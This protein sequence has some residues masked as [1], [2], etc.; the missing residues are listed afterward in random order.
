[1]AWVL[2][3][4]WGYRGHEIIGNGVDKYFD[5][6]MSQFH[7]WTPFLASHSSDAD[8]RK[9]S[10]KSEGS[11]HYLDID[12][13]PEFIETG[14]I[15]RNLDTLLALYGRSFVESQGY[16]PWATITSYD[17]L[18][19]CFKRL[20]FDKAQFFAADLSHYVA[21]GYMPL[22]LTRNYDG[23]YSNNKGIHG[24]YESDMIGMFG[25][26]VNLEGGKVEKV[27]SVSDYIFTYMFENYIY[28]DS[29]LMAD[30]Y[31][32]SVNANTTSSQYVTALWKKSHSW[33]KMFFE[34]ASKS[35]ADLLY[36]AW[37]EAGSPDFNSK[38][39][40]VE[41][42]SSDFHFDIISFS[43]LDSTIELKFA[44]E[45]QMNLTLDVYRLNG[46]TVF[47]QNIGQIGIGDYQSSYSIS[48]LKSGIYIVSLQSEFSRISKKIMVE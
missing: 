14:D 42:F 30:D 8:K 6:E 45:K 32:K 7:S 22:H 39:S 37:L 27:E 16:L 9:S 44:V 18:V 2:L 40:S 21:D 35:L 15:P 36:T 13:Y 33:T 3:S 34:N 4:S 31:A 12:N 29:I 46:Q 24:R 11:K 20:D 1:M 48:K 23:Q 5:L 17:S 38:P 43:N 19:N 25:Y 10:D 41:L 26:D 47:S 28:M